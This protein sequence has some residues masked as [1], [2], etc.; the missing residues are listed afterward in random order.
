MKAGIKAPINNWGNF[1]TWAGTQ[2]T[3]GYT[4]LK[5]L[6]ESPSQ[7]DTWEEEPTFWF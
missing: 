1:P 2:D 4:D 7:Q 5:G 6:P 3:P